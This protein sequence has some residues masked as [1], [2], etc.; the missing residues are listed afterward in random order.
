MI[1]AYA[2]QQPKHNWYMQTDKDSL[3]VIEEFMKN[4]TVPDVGTVSCNHRSWY[5]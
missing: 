1:Y 4:V 3:L 2:V 5:G